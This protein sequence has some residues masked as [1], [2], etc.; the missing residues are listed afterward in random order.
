MPVAERVIDVH[1][2]NNNL[3]IKS[4]ITKAIKC[5]VGNLNVRALTAMCFLVISLYLLL[6]H[7]MLY[8]CNS[9]ITVV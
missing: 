3:I 6:W 8:G 9:R 2:C 1:F 7:C 5:K 4:F